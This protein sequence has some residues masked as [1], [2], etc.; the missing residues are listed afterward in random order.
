MGNEQADILKT[1]YQEHYEAQITKAMDD[2]FKRTRTYLERLHHSLDDSTTDKRKDGKPKQKR[3]S[4]ST[5]DG[6]LDMIDMLK[7]CNLTGDTQMEAVRAKLEGQFR[8]VGRMPLSPE[9]LR[10]DRHLRAET[11]TVVED[12]IRNL[13]TIDL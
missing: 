6:V 13:P 1:Q 7:M 5:F 11:K 10:E 2:V 12:V 9:A 3:L 8:G 4:T